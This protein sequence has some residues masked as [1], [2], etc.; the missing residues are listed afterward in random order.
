MDYY[1]LKGFQDWSTY[2]R[3]RGYLLFAT[4]P[5]TPCRLCDFRICRSPCKIHSTL[6]RQICWTE[7]MTSITRRSDNFT[8][9]LPSIINAKFG[10]EPR[11]PTAD[12]SWR[13]RT[14][15]LWPSPSQACIPRIRFRRVNVSKRKSQKTKVTSNHCLRLFDKLHA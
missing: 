12:L 4:N 6:Q 15:W 10:R 9:D 1:H 8:T 11:L 5:E 2:T 3:Y 14:L 7:K 13:E